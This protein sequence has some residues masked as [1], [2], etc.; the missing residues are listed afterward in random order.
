MK[1]KRM[2]VR[3]SNNTTLD[4]VD[5]W[6]LNVPEAPSSICRYQSLT[7]GFFLVVFLFTVEAASCF[8]CFAAVESVVVEQNWAFFLPEKCFTQILGFIYDSR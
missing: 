1:M 7:D 6:I 8:A 3:E 4:S 5:R 2:W